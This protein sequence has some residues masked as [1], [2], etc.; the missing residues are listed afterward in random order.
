MTETSFPNDLEVYTKKS[1][2][3]EDNYDRETIGIHLF[4]LTQK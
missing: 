3:T 2:T 1:F 4:L